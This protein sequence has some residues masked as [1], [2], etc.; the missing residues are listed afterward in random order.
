MFVSGIIVIFSL[1]TWPMILGLYNQISVSQDLDIV[2][3]STLHQSMRN[4][5]FYIPTLEEARLYLP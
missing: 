5:R 3:S 2:E 4:D 1:V